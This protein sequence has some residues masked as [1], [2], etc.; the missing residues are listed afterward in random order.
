MAK[1]NRDQ[2]VQQYLHFIETCAF[3]LA[4]SEATATP[5]RQVSARE[6]QDKYGLACRNL[7]VLLFDR[8]QRGGRNLKGQNYKTIW[9][10]NRDNVLLFRQIRQDGQET[11]ARDVVNA[12]RSMGVLPR[13][14]VKVW[15]P[16]FSSYTA[17]YLSGQE[18][19]EARELKRALVSTERTYWSDQ[20]KLRETLQ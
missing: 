10:L 20:K 18:L 4:L 5:Q 11:T 9:K 19:Q 15:A 13:E 1:T 8:V 6:V 14:R 12:F 16:D 7:F 17:E 3:D 2:Q